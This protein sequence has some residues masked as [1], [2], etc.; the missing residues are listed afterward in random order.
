MSIG[1]SVHNVV[2]IYLVGL[3]TNNKSSWIKHAGHGVRA[4]GTGYIGGAKAGGVLF[5]LRNFW[6]QH[7]RQLDIR[8]AAGDTAQVTVWAYS[9]EVSF[10]I[11]SAS[12]AI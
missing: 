11:R 4:N 7:P 1:G 10:I 2:L 12:H 5:G 3:R 8:G 6:E 9:P